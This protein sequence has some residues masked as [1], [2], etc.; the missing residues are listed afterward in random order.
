MVGPKCHLNV[1][2][3]GRTDGKFL[4]LI[5]CER[6]EV[7]NSFDISGSDKLSKTTGPAD[8]HRKLFQIKK[9]FETC[10]GRFEMESTCLLFKRHGP[11]HMLEV[12]WGSTASTGVEQPT[13]AG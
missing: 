8:I 12:I 1:H 6:T 9:H 11:H 7:S 13:R 10:C 4:N 5:G 3:F 2:D